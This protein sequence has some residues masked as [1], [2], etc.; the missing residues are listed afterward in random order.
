MAESNR[1]SSTC[2]VHIIIS[3]M[4]GH[5]DGVSDHH[6]DQIVDNKHHT[7]ATWLPPYGAWHVPA[8][9]RPPGIPYY[10]CST[11]GVCSLC[12]YSCG[13]GTPAG[14]WI[15]WH[16]SCSCACYWSAHHWDI[17][18]AGAPPGAVWSF[19]L[20]R[21]SWSRSCIEIVTCLSC[22]MHLGGE[23]GLGLGWRWSNKTFKHDFSGS[24][25]KFIQ[26]QLTAV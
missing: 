22:L 7:C 25:Q 8:G 5:K 23:Y 24:T 16:I 21:M 26:I 18:P 17:D 6:G 19:P 20:W 3:S 14:L 13:L 12:G 4:H 15:S 2:T 1:D 10:R 11:C 9:A